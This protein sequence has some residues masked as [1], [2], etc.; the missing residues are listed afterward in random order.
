MS[1]KKISSF[2]FWLLYALPFAFF[3]CL[4]SLW[5]F[6]IIEKSQRIELQA[7]LERGLTTFKYYSQSIE[8]IADFLQN[9]ENLKGKFIHISKA[10][11]SL[12]LVMS[13]QERQDLSVY[14]E[15]LNMPH[16]DKIQFLKDQK[17][18]PISKKLHYLYIAK[19][20]YALGKK[21]LLD[22]AQDYSKYSQLHQGLHQQLSSV[23]RKFNFFDILYVRKKDMRVIY[24][25]EKS[26]DFARPLNTNSYAA[27]PL[28]QSV[29][30]VIETENRNA[31]SFHKLSNNKE[32]Q[33]NANTFISLPVKH[34]GELIG[35]LVL[36]LSID[37][38]VPIYKEM[39]LA[40]GEHMCWLDFS[41]T[42]YGCDFNND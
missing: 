17:Y 1:I 38:Y 26:H 9:N 41:E 25:T 36:Q 14:Y 42:V 12:D 35:V 32:Y 7:K 10:L 22:H 19:N 8:S 39:T 24:S 28:A 40:D 23:S 4:S 16:K 18:D 13:K 27:S 21:G 34:E 29:K 3:F 31:S 30:K 20:P 11:D 2:N 15:K 6:N 37:S 33:N 5:V